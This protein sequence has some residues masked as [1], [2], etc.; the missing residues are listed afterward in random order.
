MSQQA[1]VSTHA[2][3]PGLT[4][5]LA[6]TSVVLLVGSQMVLAAR[7]GELGHDAVA[8][9]AAVT[10][11][12]LLLMLPAA[13]GFVAWRRM[14]RVRI[15]AGVLAVVFAA[16]LLMR[17]AHFGTVPIAE[18]D[19]YRYLWDGALTAYGYNPYSQSPASISA[20]GT[21]LDGELGQIAADGRHVLSEINFPDLR[22]I[23]PGTAQVLFALGHAITP[24]SVDGLRLILLVTDLTAFALLLALLRQL[25]LSPFWAAAFW[26]NPLAVLVT[27]NQVHIDAAMVPLLLGAL[28]AGQ[29]GR[30]AASGLLVG[31]AAGVKIWP[32][33]LLPLLARQFSGDW[34]KIAALIATFSLVGAAVLAPLLLSAMQPGSGLSA[35]AAKWANN[36]GFYAWL[37]WTLWALLPQSIPTEALLRGGIALAAG[38]TALAVAR[39]PIRGLDDFLVRALIVAAVVFYLS[40]AQFPWYALWFLPLAIVTGCIPLIFATVLLPVY[41]LFFPLAEIGDRNVFLYGVALIHAVPVLV[42]LAADRWLPK[43]CRA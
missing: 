26:L 38:V 21:S 3:R 31:L 6:A 25:G 29:S 5:V 14:M 18:T 24:F 11:L 28:I 4:T 43:R 10:E 42:W 8:R 35:Y 41:Y 19:H 37:S 1:T 15:S 40:P 32:I 7:S 23:Y 22:T 9:F 20:A 17:I 16:G 33:L 13:V 39:N 34:R 2:S 30:A 12:M 27:A 36:N